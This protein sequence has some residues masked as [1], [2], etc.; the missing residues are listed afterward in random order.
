MRLLA[1]AA[2]LVP[3]LAASAYDYCAKPGRPPV[4]ERASRSAAVDAKIDEVAAKWEATL[5]A[6]VATIRRSSR[7]AGSRGRTR[8]LAKRYLKWQRKECSNEND[9]DSG[10]ACRDGG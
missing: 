10:G 6:I 3:C 2:L 1:S 9:N 4:E 8:C 7:A 5:N